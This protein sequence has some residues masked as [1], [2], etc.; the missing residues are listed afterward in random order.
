MAV[1]MKEEPDK[2]ERATP[3]RFRKMSERQ[4]ETEPIALL[5]TDLEAALLRHF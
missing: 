3:A 1:G 2:S 5:V 4:M